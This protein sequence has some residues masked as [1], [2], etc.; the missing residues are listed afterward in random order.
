VLLFIDKIFKGIAKAIEEMERQQAEQAAK[1]L[2][3]LK[4]ARDRRAAVRQSVEQGS[5]APIQLTR[6]HATKPPV[7]AHD[8]HSRIGRYNDENVFDEYVTE[9][10]DPTDKRVEVVDLSTIQSKS[11]FES[12]RT[13]QIPLA[14]HALR[15][16]SQPNGP[17]DACILNE[18]FNRPEH[19]WDNE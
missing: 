18:I 12:D 6:Q 8:T 4:A 5:V 7:A 3:T 13:H 15:I 17:R 2:A 14:P 1:Q 16:L 9:H 19:R 11:S 10:H